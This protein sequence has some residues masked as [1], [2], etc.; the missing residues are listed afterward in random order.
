MKKENSEKNQKKEK[1]RKKMPKRFFVLLMIAGAL[2]AAFLFFIFFYLSIQTRKIE[3]RFQDD[4]V[5]IEWE[6]VNADECRLFPYDEES[7]EYISDGQNQEKI[8]QDGTIQNGAILK[9]GE[10]EEIGLRL[11]AVKYV[12]LFGYQIPIS[13]RSRE[14]TIHPME[15]V[16]LYSYAIPEEKIA[17]LL[18]QEEDDCEYEVYCM[19]DGNLWETTGNNI[20]MLDFQNEFAIPD[21][22][23]PFWAAVR[24]VHREE[25][26]TVYGP[27][28]EYVMI[29][30]NDLLEDNMSLCWEQIEEC[31]YVL[32]WQESYGEWYEVQQ[33]SEEQN[34]W[35]S[36]CTLDSAQEMV[37]QTEHL[38][39]N[40]QVRF[41]VVTY[42]N[43]EEAEREEFQTEP[44]EITFH[45]DMSTL[46][47]TIWPVMPL[48]IMEQ[49][50]EGAILGEVPEGQALCVLGEEDGCFQV[51]YQGCLG[52]IDSDFCMIN[53]PEYLGDLCEYDITNS[54]SS[55]FR[56][57]EYDIP[58]ITD[59]VV[60]GYEN[61]C[62]GYEDY[63]VPYLY[64]CTAKLYQAILNAAAD[65]YGLRIY[66]AFRPNEASVYLYETVG[67][68]LDEPVPI[69]VED[70]ESD[71]N[72]ESDE[73][74]GRNEN[75]ESDG[76]NESNE[77]NERNERNENVEDIEI[78]ETE[79][80]TE[81]EE[82]SETVQN[83][84]REDEPGAADGDD[85]IDAGQEGTGETYWSVMTDAGHYRLG[86]FLAPSVSTH[87]RGIAL[88][89]TLIDAET[90]EDLPMQTQIHD[91]SWYSVTGNN[92]EN[93]ILLAQYMKD[94]GYNDLVTEWWHFQDDET[95]NRIGVQF[96]LTQGVSVEGWKK[97]DTGWRYRL[98]DGSYYSNTTVEID[99]RGYV[100]DGEGYCLKENS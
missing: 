77:S 26:Y 14:L 66:D 38:P 98:A 46:Y 18:W 30:R 29:T 49:P 84:G 7:G 58:E 69:I 71:E 95:R 27:I 51:E 79:Q 52:Y 73:R 60:S 48:K 2:S 35:I 91:L 65:G 78:P 89:L 4:A 90:K 31:Q 10:E 81:G 41:R 86:S 36:K 19:N 13:G 42:N 56:V 96:Y 55:V 43:R 32:K 23:N 53:L 8:I 54:V 28:S 85:M 80:I 44:S 11:Q 87:N 40:A 99:G 88:D 70:G 59:S 1:C 72:D 34:R 47:C 15:A 5:L 17:F 76:R 63:L 93:A 6:L 37:Y 92:N 82:S 33:W 61:V 50:K 100:F 57:H 22:S 67:A 24:V 21:R 25:D 16:K 3:V 20:I 39:S 62:L 83:D 97:D 45:T 68:L 74:N 9:I 12:N 94:A 64:P 75:I